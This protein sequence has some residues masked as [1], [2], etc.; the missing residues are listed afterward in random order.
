MKILLVFALTVL[1]AES[2][3]YSGFAQETRVESRKALQ[4]QLTTYLRERL[5]EAEQVVKQLRQQRD[6]GVITVSEVLGAEDELDR[7]RLYLRL[8]TEANLIADHPILTELRRTFGVPEI[9]KGPKSEIVSAVIREYLQDRLVRAERAYETTRAL[10]EVGRATESELL[11]TK[12]NLEGLKL[13][14]N[15]HCLNMQGAKE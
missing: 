6:E 3:V 11:A 9:A 4:D 2:Q 5:A 1:V 10:R 12:S 15:V 13:L 8:A 14:L 7:W